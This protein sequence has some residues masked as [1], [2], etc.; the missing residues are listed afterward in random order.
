MHELPTPSEA[1]EHIHPLIAR[2]RD[3]YRYPFLSSE[4]FVAFI[5]PPGDAVVFFVEEP[6]RYR[7]T[8]DVAVIL[9][10]LAA[11]HPGRFRVGVLLPQEARPLAPRYGLAR[12]P[13][14]VFMRGGEYVGAIEG[15]RDWAGYLSETAALLQAPTRHPPTIGVKIAATGGS[16][17]HS[18]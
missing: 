10:E 16:H 12:W 9:P 18:D 6:A 14:L 4:D 2:L 15:L 13:A 7:E 17:P 11:A 8:L 1:P 5:S 3:Q